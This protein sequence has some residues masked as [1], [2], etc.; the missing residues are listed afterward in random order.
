MHNEKGVI[1]VSSDHLWW[2]LFDNAEWRI[3]N[4]PRGQYNEVDDWEQVDDD[5]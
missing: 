2:K 4:L 5:N 1:I 3:D